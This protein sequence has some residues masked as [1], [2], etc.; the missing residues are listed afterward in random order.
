MEGVRVCDG[1]SEGVRRVWMGGVRVR[2]V[3]GWYMDGRGEGVRR[4]VWMEG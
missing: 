2:R 3:C 4:G 1:G